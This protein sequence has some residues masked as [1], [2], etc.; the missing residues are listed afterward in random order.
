MYQ[1]AKRTILLLL[2]TIMCT[3][4]SAQTIL[5]GKVYDSQSRAPLPGV[6]VFVKKLQKGVTTD[7]RGYYIISLPQ[8]K[9][10]I[11]YSFI[12]YQKAMKKVSIADKSVKLDVA[13]SVATEQLGEVFVTAKSEARKIREKAMP[14]S[15]ITMDQIKGT[16][17]DVSDVLSKTS[18][19]KIR[20]SGGVGSASRISVRGLE[21]KRIGF[22]IDGAPMNENS[23]FVNVND[24]PVDLI[25]R[26][27]VYKGIVP[28]KYG[29][30]AIG[31]AVNIVLKEYPPHYFDL[32]YSL[33]S[34]NTQQVSAV[35][36]RNNE[37][38]GLEFGLGGF[39]TYADNNYRME[40]PLQKG[41]HV[42]RDHDLYKKFVLG[43]GLTSTSWY[44]DEIEFEPV[45]VFTTK[46]IQGIEYNIQGAVS[47]SD[48]YGLSNKAEKTD[49][50][51]KGLDLD[52]SSLYAYSIYK[53]QDK[54]MHKFTWDG[55]MLPPVHA[56]G[57]EIGTTPNDSY[58]QKHTFIQ[59]TNLNYLLNEQNSL[60]FNS[61]FN[62]AKGIPKDTLKDAVIGYKTNF[63]SRMNSW[64]AGLAHEYH[65]LNNKFTNSFTVKY[66]YYSMKTRIADLFGMG[67]ID[68][69]NME[70]MDFGISNAM[71]FRFTPSFL[72]KASVAYD[73]RLPSENELI[74]DGFL[75]T[76]S[77]NLEPERNRSLNLGFMYDATNL[78]R[79][80][81]QF[82]VNAFYMELS[83]M[84]RF[85]GG[86]L[87]SN[88]QNFGEMRTL[89]VEAEVKWDATN[90]LYLYG[91]ATY[92]DL[93]DIREKQP[94]SA[95]ANPT[96]GDRMPNIPYL[97]ANSGFELHKENLFG[98]KGQNVRLYTDCSFVEEYFYDF[99]QSIYQERRI[100]RSLTF[101]SGMEYSFGDRRITLALQANNITDEKVMSEFNRPLPGRNFGLKVRYVW[102]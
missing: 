88:Y 41:R 81:F 97:F 95:V 62:F 58:N 76:P 69:V 11:A 8:G 12:G 26:I 16:V 22:F 44:F 49:F 25:D 98:G 93:R 2:V 31:G 55:E 61:V 1:S 101:N 102:K 99:E 45:I 100:P 3:G 39:Y 20:S 91:N 9:F 21:G 30:S 27:E 65:T 83:N 5:T 80:R 86:S 64:V 10:D 90:F 50:L 24:I 71:R 87:Q 73:V 13:L 7:S 34:F 57:G 96:K 4:L 48:A 74:G 43:G 28:A 18:G 67:L 38:K 54:A 17:S 52:M 37:K 66:Y 78:N 15:V 72:V 42:E 63:T 47:Y 36:K 33:R 14:I 56:L 23:D 85:T 40:L 35:I 77:G 79:N 92:Q 89:G 59:K 46:E 53:F 70:K 19:I 94:G 51:V 32:S 84:I 60:N 6:S 68:D 29:G 82:E 75:I